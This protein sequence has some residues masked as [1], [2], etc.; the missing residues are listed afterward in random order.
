MKG[1]KGFRQAICPLCAGDKFYIFERDGCENCPKSSSCK[2]STTHNGCRI[3]RCEVC[4]LE[5]T[6][7]K[8]KEVNHANIQKSNLP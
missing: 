6:F 5:F 8:Y 7:P 2:Y 1:K 3:Y 4:E